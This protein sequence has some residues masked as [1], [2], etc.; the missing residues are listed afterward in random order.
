MPS[1]TC[2][3][4]RV[5]RRLAALA[6]ATA[7]AGLLA[8]A[9]SAHD[10]WLEPS[11]YRL[12]AGEL[13]RLRFL[14]GERLEG[15]DVP[16]RDERIVRFVDRG[17]S[18]TTDVLGRDGHSPA[19]LL[20]PREA[21]LHVVGYESTTSLVE[22]DAPRFEAYL[23]EEGLEHVIATRAAAGEAHAAGRER[24]ARCA[25]TLLSVGEGPVQGAD[26]PLGLTFELVAEGDPLEASSSDQARFRALFRGEPLEGALVVALWRDATR[27]PATCSARTDAEGRVTLSLPPRGALLVKAVHMTPVTDG[28]PSADW[29]SFWASLTFERGGAP[30]STSA[31]S[32]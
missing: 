4:V 31:A 10:F 13:V 1:T 12:P 7:C 14:V 25:K 26:V 21:G 8:S 19:G 32:H 11:G 20:R 22:L 16:R 2:S 9:V 17:P 23:R 5:T 24:Y 28:D 18:A 6:R 29:E 27:G 15:A 30:R 3:S